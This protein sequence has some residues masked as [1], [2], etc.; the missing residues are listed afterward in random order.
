MKR[1]VAALFAVS[2][3]AQAQA[4]EISAITGSLFNSDKV[5][6]ADE[7]TSMDLGA[8]YGSD[9]VD[10]KSWFV[11]LNFA[12]KSDKLKLAAGDKTDKASSI[13]VGGG[14]AWWMKSLSSDNFIPFVTLG[15]SVVSGSELKH[16]VTTGAKGSD[17]KS[18]NINYGSDVGIRI[19]TSETCFIDL[20]TNLFTNTLHGTSK[21]DVSKRETTKMQLGFDSMGGLGATTVGLGMKI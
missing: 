16:D 4:A 19:N 9:A 10:G 13:T 3:A 12:N 21:D 6:N 15:A 20:S 14:M 7:S 17:V 1:I 18:M 11:H 2:V 5:K 8:K